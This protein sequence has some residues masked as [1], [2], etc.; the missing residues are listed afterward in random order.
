MLSNLFLLLVWSGVKYEEKEDVAR[1][2]EDGDH[3]KNRSFHNLLKS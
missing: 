3:K 1:R 2:D